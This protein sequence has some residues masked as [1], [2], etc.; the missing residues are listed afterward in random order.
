MSLKFTLMIDSEYLQIN[1]WSLFPPDVLRINYTVGY[2]FIKNK[3]IYEYFNTL[4]Y[5]TLSTLT[6]TLNPQP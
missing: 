3:G 4:P 2:N 1:N 5:R 6:P